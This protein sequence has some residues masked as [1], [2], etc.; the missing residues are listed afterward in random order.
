MEVSFDVVLRLSLR[1]SSP[2]PSPFPF[3]FAFHVRTCNMAKIPTTDVLHST[4]VMSPI[5]REYFKGPPNVSD[6][7]HKVCVFRVRTHGRGTT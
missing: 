2:F 3:P 7:L 4:T 5:A 6:A 1:A